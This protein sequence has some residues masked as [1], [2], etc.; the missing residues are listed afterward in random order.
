MGRDDSVNIPDQ[1]F[2]VGD[3]IV[4]TQDYWPYLKKGQIG[5]IRYVRCDKVCSK[6]GTVGRAP[7]DGGP[8]YVMEWFYIGVFG[9]EPVQG[10]RI[11]GLSPVNI[12]CEASPRLP[13]LLR[14][15]GT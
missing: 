11:D 12:I 14:C 8:H 4:T 2:F 7:D 5:Y 9:Q 3:L 10:V 13:S 6:G 15:M 1:K